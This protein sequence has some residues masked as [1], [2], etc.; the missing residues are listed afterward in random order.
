MLTEIIEEYIVDY[1]EKK[2]QFADCNKVR[3]VGAFPIVW[4]GNIDNYLNSKTRVVTVGL[5]PSNKEFQEQNERF[6]SMNLDLPIDSQEIADLKKN[7]NSYFEVNPYR[8]FCKGEKVLNLFDASYYLEG[9]KNSGRHQAIH[10]DIYTSIA[11]DPTWGSLEKEVRQ[12][13]SNLGLF[14]K[15]LDFLNPNIILV[16]TN[17]EVFREV[18]Q[19]SRYIHDDERTYNANRTSFYV[20]KYHNRERE[21]QVLYWMTNFRGT[22]FAPKLVFI[23]KSLEELASVFR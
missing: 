17:K 13:I 21:E 6:S 22:V 14:N 11:T 18:F 9:V 1:I 19:E 7:L 8:W 16:S 4:F 23:K 12:R 3:I 2:K 10:I 20:R 5:N 15:L